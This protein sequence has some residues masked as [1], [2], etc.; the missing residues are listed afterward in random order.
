MEHMTQSQ[1]SPESPQRLIPVVAAVI[2]RDGRFL[3]ARRTEP[4]AL[5]GL[6]EFN[7]QSELQ[8]QGRLFV[9]E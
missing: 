8:M 7:P 9:P 2:E 3:A 6:W 1:P 5:K 4:E